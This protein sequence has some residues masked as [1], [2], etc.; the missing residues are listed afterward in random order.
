MLRFLSPFFGFACALEAEAAAA[1]AKTLPPLALLPLLELLA[2]FV[3]ESLEPALANAIGLAAS[4]LDC[5]LLADDGAE[6]PA[7]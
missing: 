5:A 2:G 4:E 7:F 6:L 1:A 3:S